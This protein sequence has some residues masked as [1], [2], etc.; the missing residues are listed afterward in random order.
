VETRNLSNIQQTTLDYNVSIL[1]AGNYYL[2]LQTVQ[3]IR[4]LPVAVQH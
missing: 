1:P 4:T 2:R 3:G